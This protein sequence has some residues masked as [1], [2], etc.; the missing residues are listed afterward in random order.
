M[1]PLTDSQRILQALN[2]QDQTF[3]R[4]AVNPALDT[5]AKT[6]RQ[7]SARITEAL[8]PVH[9]LAERMQT[10]EFRSAA[11][12]ARQVSTGLAASIPHRA[13]LETARLPVAGVQ[14]QSVADLG[15]LVRS[16]RKAMKMNQSEFAA[17]AGV[18]R[19]FVSELESGK[20]SLEFDRVMA[21]LQAA[22]I[23]LTA[24]LRN[25]WC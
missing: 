4:L 14:V 24:R 16:A 20:P 15:A 21:C 18:G 13:H 5:A 2:E 11:E 3:R 23:D 12:I 7:I 19:R 9:K 6:G 17:H 8:S 25:R 1:R 22:G 10:P